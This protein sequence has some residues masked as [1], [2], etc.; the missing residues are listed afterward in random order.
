MMEKLGVEKEELLEELKT[1]YAELR[2][3]FAK[4]GSAEM[5]SIK[6]KIDELQAE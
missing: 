3:N 2:K 1:K 6:A 4:T 5:E